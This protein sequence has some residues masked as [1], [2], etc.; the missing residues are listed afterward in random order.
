MTSARETAQPVDPYAVLGVKVGVTDEQ[1]RAR[2]RELVRKYHPDVSVDKLLAHER[3]LRIVDAYQQLSDPVV[4]LE[5]EAAKSARQR[6]EERRARERA[7]RTVAQ[8]VLRAT[9]LRAEVYLLRGEAEPAAAMLKQVIAQHPNSAEAF[10]LLGEA[11]AD[12]GEVDRAITMMTFAAQLRPH[13]PVYTARLSELAAQPRRPVNRETPSLKPEPVILAEARPF[14]LWAGRV[15]AV[16]FPFAVLLLAHRVWSRPS[17]PDFLNVPVPIFWAG[18]IGSFLGGVLLPLAGV[19]RR[20]DAD[21]SGMTIRSPS[22]A[23]EVPIPLYLMVIG[24]ISA[25]LALVAYLAVALWEETWSW[26]AVAVFALSLAIAGVAALLV[27]DQWQLL[28]GFGPN[29]PYV[30]CML[31]W[32]VGSSFLPTW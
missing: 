30:L 31:G 25:Y 5:L 17:S 26:S 29:V 8:D 6:A 2:Y 10:R 13:Y 9:L 11:Y 1:L 14:L 18:V 32:A 21:W 4:R 12:L 28:I 3:F 15:G 20:F 22:S 16:A 23:A 19:V 24:L 7:Q 27:P